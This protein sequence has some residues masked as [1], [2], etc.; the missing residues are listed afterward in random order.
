MK[1]D[2]RLLAIGLAAM[3]AVGACGA[4]PRRRRARRRPR[5]PRARRHRR[6]I[7]RAR[8]AVRVGRR[9]RARRRSG[10]GGHP[11]RR[12]RRRDRLLD[13]LPVADLRRVHQGHDRPLRGDL[14]GRQGQLGGPP[15]HVPGR[16]EQRVRRRQRPGRHQPLGQRGLGLR[17]RVARTCSSAS[18]TWSRR[19]SRTSTSTGLWNSQL[20]D[21]ENFQFP[22]YQGISV[23]L[24]NKRI[25]EEGAG[26]TVADFPTTVDG[27]ARRCARRSRTRP[28]RCAPSA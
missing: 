20:V 10:R 7:R 2:K 5:P 24:I 19:R 22:W 26:L 25:Y 17:L 16:P 8:R 18:T 13:V 21:G 27:A 15:G 1:I 14:S 12:G 9:H 3:F 6:R 11:G 4:A 23:E 28:A